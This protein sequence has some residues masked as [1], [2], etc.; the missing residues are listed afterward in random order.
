VSL[1]TKTDC[2]APTV[3]D[4]LVHLL[5]QRLRVGLTCGVPT[6]LDDSDGGAK[7]GDGDVKSPLQGAGR[8]DAGATCGQHGAAF[9]RGR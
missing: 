6:A 9:R 7:N 8:Q 5:T 4:V 1:R 2:A 3:L